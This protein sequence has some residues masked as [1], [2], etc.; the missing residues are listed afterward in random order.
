[1]KEFI[2][3]KPK[4]LV[5]FISIVLFILPFFWI[6]P[7]ELEL[8]GDSSRLYLYD[9]VSYLETTSL[10][11]LRPE[12]LGDIRPD[13][14]LLPFMLVLRAIYFIF[15]SPY[16]LTCLLNSLKLVGSF[17][18]V[19]LIVVEILK[20][21]VKGG[22]LFYVQMSGILTSFFYTPFP[23]LAPPIQFP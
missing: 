2:L 6:K 22:N 11:S 10:Y 8:G 21:Y 17:L 19:Y 13:Q 9:P 14:S 1:M 18:F 23:T 15:H 5:L 7:G 16:I 12:G 3:L 4:I 20:N